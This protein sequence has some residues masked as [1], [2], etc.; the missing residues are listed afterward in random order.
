MYDMENVNCSEDNFSNISAVSVSFYLDNFT[1]NSSATCK[2]LENAPI[3]TRMALAKAAILASMAF[4]SLIG[5]V[6]T[7]LTIAITKKLRTKSS[8]YT[9]LFQVNCF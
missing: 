1:T 9:L 8:L 2:I 7:L 6:A 3:F 4:A 5:N